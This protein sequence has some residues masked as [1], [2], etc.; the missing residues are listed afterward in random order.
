MFLCP[1]P[2]PSGYMNISKLLLQAHDLYCHHIAS[3]LAAVSGSVSLHR[4]SAFVLS[5]PQTFILFSKL[6]F[7]TSFSFLLAFS[8]AWC[9]CGVP[10]A[11]ARYEQRQLSGHCHGQCQCG[12]ALQLWRMKAEKTLRMPMHAS[13]VLYCWSI[14]GF[15]V[16]ESSLLLSCDNAGVRKFDETMLGFQD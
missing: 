8:G 9:L 12:E 3:S 10:L 5:L 13:C 14:F 1:P 2:P 15:S 4:N 16:A 7:F 6:I 11:L